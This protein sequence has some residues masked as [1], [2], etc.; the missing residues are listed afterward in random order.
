MVWYPALNI[1]RPLTLPTPSNATM[2]NSSRL[3]AFRNPLDKFVA[4]R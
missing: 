1:M 4:Q 2:G 3:Y